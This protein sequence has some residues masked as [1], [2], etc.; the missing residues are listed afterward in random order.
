VL[1]LVLFLFILTIVGRALWQLAGGVLE[2]LTGPAEGAS[3]PHGGSARVPQKGVQ[4]VRDPVCGTFV[5]P[6][7]SITLAVKGHQV[8]FC[9]ARCRDTYQATSA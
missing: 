1:R 6:D 2:G 5:V 3:T 7:R 9:S 8:Y 4:M